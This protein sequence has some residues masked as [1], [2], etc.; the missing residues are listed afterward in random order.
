[1]YQFSLLFV[2][3]KPEMLPVAQRKKY[4]GTVRAPK[5]ISIGTPQK[6]TDMHAGSRLWGAPAACN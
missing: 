1:M 6:S 5:S 4:R 3:E 2:N